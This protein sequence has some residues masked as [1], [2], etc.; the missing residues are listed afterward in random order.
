MEKRNIIIARCFTWIISILSLLFLFHSVALPLTPKKLPYKWQNIAIGGG[1]SVPGLIIHPQVKDLVYIRTDVGSIYKWDAEGKKWLPLWLWPSYEKWNLTAVASI[2]VDPSDQSGRILYAAAGKYAADW[3]EPPKGEIFKST[4]VGKTWKSTSLRLGVAANWD[5][6][7]G[8]R[9]VVDPNN[10]DIVYYASRMDGLWRSKD[11]A[12]T[13][14]KVI[15]APTGNKIGTSVQD[16]RGLTFIVFD[17]N[18]GDK[19]AGCKTIYLGSWVEGVY[20]S[21]DGGETWDKLPACPPN[22]YRAVLGPQGQLYVTHEKGL[23]KFDGNKWCDITPPDHKGKRFVA[24]TVDPANLNHIIT[25]PQEWA[26]N[27]PIFRSTDGGQTWTE[28]KYR[29]H[30]DVP[31]SPDSFWSAATFTLTI[32]PHNN[33]RV[34]YTDW[35]HT[36][37]TPDITQDVTDWY[38]FEYGHEVIVPIALASPPSGQVRLFSGVA[39]VGGFDHINIEKFPEKMTRDKGLPKTSTTGI[40]FAEE[41]PSFVVRA[42]ALGWGEVGE[43]GCGYTLDGGETWTPMPTKPYEEATGG[44]V[45]VSAS[46]DRVVWMPQESCLFYTQNYGNSWLESYG[47]P[48]NLITQFF[49][50]DIPLAS[51]RVL[52]NVFY[53]YAQGEFFRSDNGAEI[54]QHVGNLVKGENQ[55]PIVKAA[56]GMQKE[57]WVS[58]NDDGLWKSS[59]GGD[60][61]IKLPA[62]RQALLFDFGQNPPSKNHPAVFVF[63]KINNKTGVF[64]SDDM[65]KSWFRIDTFPN[66]SIGAQPGTMAGDR[67]VF[68]RVYIGTNGTGIFYS[69]PLEN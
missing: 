65:G 58:L 48:E 51:D 12:R 42:N 3:A 69:Q 67:Q 39:D 2:A 31:W 26:F 45:A 11:A 10:G 57:V 21:I 56:P 34:W 60:N 68:G 43:I 53:I 61:F 64:R 46:G 55:R 50:T 5:Q 28:I 30:C 16:K 33:K 35:Y 52:N 7:F 66:P 18:T 13:W 20:R 27:M 25:A 32:D 9:L 47:A 37:V 22:T 59:D 29:K 40:D 36:W 6:R 62:V 63:G 23:T 41:D 4:D 14:E 15:T 49:S 44:R 19:N 8:E 1:G 24:V 17:K 38:T 54:W